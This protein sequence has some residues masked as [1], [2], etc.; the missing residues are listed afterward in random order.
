MSC[1]IISLRRCKHVIRCKPVI[2]LIVFQ[3]YKN[4][5]GE[6][7]ISVEPAISSFRCC[8]NENLG[9]RICSCFFLDGADKI[10]RW[11]FTSH[12]AFKVGGTGGAESQFVKLCFSRSCVG[13]ATHILG[14]KSQGE[15]AHFKKSWKVKMERFA[16]P[17]PLFVYIFNSFNC[18]L[19]QPPKYFPGWCLIHLD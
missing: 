18:N 4:N 5:L 19:I 7:V 10:G 15:I 8:E 11:S 9:L 3:K 12:D 17:L 14:S 2:L 16:K 13:C 6:R 1:Y